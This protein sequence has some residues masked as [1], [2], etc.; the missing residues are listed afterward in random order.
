MRRNHLLETLL[1]TLREYDD[2]P[3][4]SYGGKHPKVD[5]SSTVAGTY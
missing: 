5:G 3:N 4:M 2:N 1:E